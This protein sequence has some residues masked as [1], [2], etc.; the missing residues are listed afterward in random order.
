VSDSVDSNGNTVKIEGLEPISDYGILINTGF[1][2][3]REQIENV[4]NGEEWYFDAIIKNSQGVNIANSFK[5][6]L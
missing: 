5:Y 2:D 3:N 1:Y 6:D 4:T